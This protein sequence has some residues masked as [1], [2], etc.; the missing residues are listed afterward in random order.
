MEFLIFILCRDKKKKKKKHGTDA[1]TIAAVS[2][3]TT[4]LL[5]LPVF[6]ILI[7]FAPISKTM[8]TR[9]FIIT[10]SQGRRGRF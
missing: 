2:E 1:F 5:L 3:T 9:F 8:S 6:L 10:I 7:Y 4:I